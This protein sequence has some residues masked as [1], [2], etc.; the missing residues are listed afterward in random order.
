LGPLLAVPF[1]V[2]QPACN[3]ADR[4]GTPGIEGELS[5]MDATERQALLD[6]LK[7]TGVAPEG[8]RSIGIRGIDRNPRALAVEGG[9]V[10]G[11]RL[12]QVTLTDLSPLRRLPALQALWLTDCGLTSVDGLADLPQ[13]SDLNLDGNKLTSLA[14]LKGL[15]ALKKLSA[16]NNQ[17]AEAPSG[18]PAKLTLTLD[19]N[20]LGKASAPT[21]AAPA[22]AAPAP[23]GGLVP[24]LPKADGS[25]T[26]KGP[27]SVEG[28]L[29]TNT[30]FSASGVYDT[31]TGAKLTRFVKAESADPTVDAEI[32]VEQGRVRLYLEEADRKNFRFVEATPG[33]PGRLRGRMVFDI[34]QYGTL[35]QSVE[36]TAQKVRYKLVRAPR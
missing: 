30:P 13:L 27:H 7:G 23:A 24:A 14:P 33:Q 1:F 25:V 2:G 8:L 3:N 5:T 28:T 29:V 18:L 11:L 4:G 35:L 20:P 12:S 9:H 31:L 19:G 34:G 10:I 15:P 17:L 36:G 16:R 22:A 26:G 32:S 21:A 6:L